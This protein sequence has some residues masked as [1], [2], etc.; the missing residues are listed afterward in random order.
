MMNLLINTLKS[1]QPIFTL[2]YKAE[3]IDNQTVI[4]QNDFMLFEILGK[5]VFDFKLCYIP[6]ETYL[7]TSSSIPLS[8]DNTDLEAL[9]KYITQQDNGLVR[10]I[11]F[12]AHKYAK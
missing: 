11:D 7:N 12:A 9:E 5:A 4:K 3:K 1:H 6:S 2:W 10:V 8:K